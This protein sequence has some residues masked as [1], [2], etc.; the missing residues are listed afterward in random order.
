LIGKEIDDS[1]TISTPGGMVEFE[2][3]SV[4]YK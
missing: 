3:I 2:I 1:V 4:E